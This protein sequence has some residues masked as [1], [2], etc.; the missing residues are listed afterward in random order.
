MYGCLARVVR[1]GDFKIALIARLSAIP[2]SC[3][4]WGCWALLTPSSLAVGLLSYR[5]V[6]TTELVSVW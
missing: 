3:R 1:K 5:Q 6:Q 4:G 2:P